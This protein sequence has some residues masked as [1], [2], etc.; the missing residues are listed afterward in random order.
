VA[1]F[2]EFILQA[3]LEAMLSKPWTDQ[4]SD[5]VS[6]Q[7][8]L[9]LG[10]LKPGQTSSAAELMQFLGLKHRPTFRNNYLDPAMALGL[11]EKTHPGSP[12]SPA[13]RYRLTDKGRQ[14]L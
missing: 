4:V 9:L 12:R 6:D 14:V 13:Q 5:Q 7:V 10:A 3:M 8:G 2:A 1:P 11:I